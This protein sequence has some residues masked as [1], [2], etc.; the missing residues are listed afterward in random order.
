MSN[1]NLPK[2]KGMEQEKIWERVFDF[3]HGEYILTPH[4]T[5]KYVISEMMKTFTITITP[6]NPNSDAVAELISWLNSECTHGTMTGDLSHDFA[7]SLRARL[8]AIYSGQPAPRMFS[9][10]ESVKWL[11]DDFPSNQPLYLDSGLWQLRS[12]DMNDVLV[13]Q[14]MNESLYDFIERC[15]S[16]FQ[17]LGIDITKNNSKQK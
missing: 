6:A 15:K 14:G 3:Y 9:V 16:Y 1:D 17:S 2:G 13:E 5:R 12:D 8:D 10:E 11:F 7:E 4:N